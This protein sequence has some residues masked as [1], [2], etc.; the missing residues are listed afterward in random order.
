MQR[1]VGVGLFWSLVIAT[2]HIIGL[3]LY[4]WLGSLLIQYSWKYSLGVVLGEMSFM[5]AVG[6]FVSICTLFLLWVIRL[7]SHSDKDK[8]ESPHA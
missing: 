1:D 5:S 3:T 7:L 4:A 6:V 2:V 8:K